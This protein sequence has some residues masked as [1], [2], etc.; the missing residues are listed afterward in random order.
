L[1]IVWSDCLHTEAKQLI[2]SHNLH[3]LFL[4]SSIG[5]RIGGPA[6]MNYRNKARKT[7]KLNVPLQC[8]AGGVDLSGIMHPKYSEL[9]FPEKWIYARE[10][11]SNNNGKKQ[12]R[13][14]AINSMTTRF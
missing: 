13:V 12:G 14:S 6:A 4:S 11:L 3:F 8:S 5:L 1:I 10:A 9:A 2:F 7:R